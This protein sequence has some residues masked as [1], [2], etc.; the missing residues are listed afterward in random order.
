MNYLAHILLADD[1]HEA[2]LGALLG[3]FVRG[4]GEADF[5]PV[6]QAEI[7]MHRRI[8]SYTDSHALVRQAKALFAPGRRR[9]AGIVL[10]I[11]YDHLLVQ[12]WSRY[13]HQPLDDFIAAF[14][15][16]LEAQPHLFPPRFAAIATRMVEED[17][18]GSYATPAGMEWAVQR[19]S[20]RLSRNGHLLREC[21]LDLRMHQAAIAGGFDQ[22][23]PQLV[24]YVRCQRAG[25]GAHVGQP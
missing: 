2:R 9:F 7:L 16:G 22:F 14:Y 24:E 23:F 18:L 1:S 12:R 21:L 13:A 10:D 3:D 5:G 20:G 25:H 17:W 15:R 6:I 11:F 19:V 8:D 4:G